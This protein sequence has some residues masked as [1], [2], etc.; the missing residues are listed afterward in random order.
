MNEQGIK[1]E[2][3][4]VT[5]AENNLSRDFDG[6]MSDERSEQDGL[7]RRGNRRR[8]NLNLND[9][10]GIPE[11]LNEEEQL[12]IDMMDMNGNSVDYTA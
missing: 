9:L 5:V 3:V 6:S 11:D 10:E 7:T 8:T 2:A 12:A 1:V 4:E